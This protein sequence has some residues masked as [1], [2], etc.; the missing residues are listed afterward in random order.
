VALSKLS[1]TLYSTEGYMGAAAEASQADDPEVA[2]QLLGLRWAINPL[3]RKMLAEPE[4]SS[5]KLALF[6][7]ALFDDIHDTFQAL[8]EQDDTSPLR[9]NDLP[10]ALQKRFIG[11]HQKYL[12]QV[13]PKE[14]VWQRKHQE[15]FVTDLQSIVPTATGTPVQLYYY[16]ELLKDSYVQAAY[17]SLGAIVLMVLLHFR[18]L[19][20]VI[21]ALLPVVIGSIWLGGFMG[22][23]RLSFNPANIMVLPLMIGIGVTNG[24]HILNRFAEEK[25]PGILGKSTGKAV[26]ISGLTTISGFGSLLLAQNQGISSLGEVMSVGLA[27]CMIAALTF[28]PALLKLLNPQNA[29]TKKQPSG[30]NARSTLGREEPR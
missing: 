11:V 29:P 16:T 6:Q 5:R 18:T 7:Q 19:S 26:F 30:D 17:Y 8:Q 21:L 1:A 24:I 27:T 25:D 3:I 13:Y 15:K 2:K 20:S 28:L 10:D 23:E 22:W 9:A 4:L 12:L 14:D